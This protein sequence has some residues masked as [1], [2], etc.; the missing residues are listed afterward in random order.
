[1]KLDIL[2]IILALDCM[3]T[4]AISGATQHLVKKRLE[5]HP[6]IELDLLEENES[7]KGTC[8][9]CKR[10]RNLTVT[11][12]LSGAP[13][14]KDKLSKSGTFKKPT[15]AENDAGILQAYDDNTKLCF[16]VGDACAARIDYFHTG[17]HYKYNYYE[18][19]REDVETELK[20]FCRK[21]KCTKK[22]ATTTLLDACANF[23]FDEFD[24]NGINYFACLMFLIYTF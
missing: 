1:M 3:K 4:Q 9:M 8:A 23:I 6:T 10:P 13:Y 12:T 16:D 21:N 19:L 7:Y 15:Q 17:Q 5:K 14:H 20:D 24:K 18:G 22:K 11:I 2:K